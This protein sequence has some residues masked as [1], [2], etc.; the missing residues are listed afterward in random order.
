MSGLKAK[1]V[2]TTSI[3]EVA[4]EFEEKPIQ[5]S[6][7][8]ELSCKKNIPISIG[9]PYLIKQRILK[10]LY[11]S[12]RI[13]GA[14]FFFIIFEIAFFVLLLRLGTI[15]YEIWILQVSIVLGY[16]IFLYSTAFS[17]KSKISKF[18]KILTS[19]FMLFFILILLFIIYVYAESLITL[20]TILILLAVYYFFNIVVILKTKVSKESKNKGKTIVILSLI[21]LASAGITTA[22][23]FL[24]NYI[25]INPQTEPELIFWCGSNQLPNDPDEL[26]TCKKYNIGFMATVRSNMIGNE[27]FIQSYKNI[28]SYGINLYFCIGGDSGFFANIDNAD[29]FLGIYIGIKQWLVN[30]SIFDDPHVV[31]FSIDAEPPKEY[32]DNM[33]KDEII[34]SISYGYNNFPSE[35]EINEAEKAIDTFTETVKKDGKECGMI[36]I[37]QLLDSSDSDG[38]L[39]LFTR[40]LYSLNIEWDYSITMLYRTNSLQS[41]DSDSEPPKYVTYSLSTM[42]GAVIEGTKFTNSEL[43]FYQNVALVQNDDDSKAD[44]RYVFVGNFKK[45]FEETQYIQKKMYKRDLDVCRHFGAEKVFFYDIKGFLGQYGWEGI[46]ELGKYNQQ[47]DKWYLEYNNSKSTLFLLFYCGLIIIDRFAFFEKDIS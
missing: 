5:K 32:E 6:Q 30:E 10:I 42:F 45:E 14:T 1:K 15:F 18:F 11:F 24:P 19:F 31:S 20:K 28:L 16:V 35:K 12:F 23:T 27:E 34:D 41:D 2:S 3:F 47:K 39:A 8:E 46:E 44:K 25:E 38:D 36:R 13:F 22:L 17:K 9:K 21:F 40:N 29:E 26:E 33:N 4:E 43:N 7:N 37:A